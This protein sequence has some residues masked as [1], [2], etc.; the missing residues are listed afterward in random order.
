MQK[1]K[2]AYNHLLGL[3]KSILYTRKTINCLLK[4]TKIKPIRNIGIMIKLC[5]T[6]PLILRISLKPKSSRKTSIIKIVEE[7]IQPL[8]LISLK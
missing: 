2:L 3:K 5:F 1:Q 6:I 8:G 4:K 7:V